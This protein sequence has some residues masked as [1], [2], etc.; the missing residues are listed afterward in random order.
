MKE[1]QNAAVFLSPAFVVKES[2]RQEGEVAF[3]PPPR[4]RSVAIG[5]TRAGLVTGRVALPER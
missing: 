2:R 3:T 1:E 4:A 5:F